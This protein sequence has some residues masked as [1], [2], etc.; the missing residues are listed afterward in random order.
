MKNKK[1]IIAVA[2]ILVLWIAVGIVDYGKVHSFEKPIFC[3]GTELADDGGSGKYVGLGYS[4][5]IE[6]NFMP[7]DEFP[8]VTK[9]TYRL[10][11]I[12][13][14]TQIRD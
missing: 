10:F 5:D 9:W 1:I 7:E 2:C 11:G 4:F 14:Q 3:V 12:E 6:G 8:G 13:L